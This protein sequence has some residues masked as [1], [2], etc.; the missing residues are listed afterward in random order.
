V[1]TTSNSKSEFPWR[2]FSIVL[3]GT[4]LGPMGGLMVGVALPTLSREYQIDLTSTVWVL[5]TYLATTTFLLP[6]IGKLG[7]QFGLKR[8]YVSGFLIDVIGTV[9]CALA[10]TDNITYLAIFRVIQ[11]IG[12]VMVFALFSAIITRYVPVER[13]GLAFGLTGGMVAISMLIGAPLAGVLCQYASWQW[14]FWLQV[15]IQILGLIVGNRVL[16]NDVNGTRQFYNATSICAWFTTTVGFTI[17]AEILKGDLE[18]GWL[19]WL[20]LVWCAG[21]VVFILAERGANS[22]FEYAIFRIRAFWV[23]ALGLLVNN[24]GI[25]VWLIFMT[26][27]IQDY[28][29]F[30]QA[31]MGMTL[32]LALLATLIS[33]PLAGRLVDRIGLRRPLLTGI[34][35]TVLSM[36]VMAVA[37]RAGNM[38][39]LSLGIVMLGLGGGLYNAPA[40]SLMM[41]SVPD[42][43][44]AK[45]SSVSSLMRNTGFLL[46]ASAGVLI[47]TLF[48]NFSGSDGR[49]YVQAFQ[50]SLLNPQSIPI[51][52]FSFSFAGLLLVSAGLLMLVGML[53]WTLPD[54]ISKSA[55]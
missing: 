38:N 34:A 29:G 35:V 19:P 54:R 32:S 6:I 30:E 17:L 10:P 41:G 39:L 8:I 51:S 13:R 18:R 52:A 24:F 46:G 27:Y 31:R 15:P 26:Y 49:S 3:I 42:L 36:L 47:F 43:L 12:S 9:L 14:I 7:T 48:L 25:Q 33:A 45:A 22:L 40:M 11:A 5:L 4:F 28:L 16:P 21:I 20:S 1:N 44:H 23:C 2:I 50:S 53:S 55:A 37:V